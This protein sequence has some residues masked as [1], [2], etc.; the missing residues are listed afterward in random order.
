[1]GLY[2][3][4][5]RINLSCQ[6]CGKNFEA[7]R[8][9]TKYCSPCRKIVSLRISNAGRDKRRAEVNAAARIRF[10]NAT[11]AQ[12][13][14]RIELQRIRRWR[15]LYKLTPEQVTQM[16]QAQNQAC[17]IC[18]KYLDDPHID[19]CHDTG[20]VRG[21]LCDPCNRGLGFFKHNPDLLDNAIGYLLAAVE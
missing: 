9:D 12:R 11:P 13:A 21:I 17:A 8:V 5:N 2:P 7:K 20:K 3:I 6:N 19:H 1:M 15:D 14:R 18:S 10:K 4:K 16:L